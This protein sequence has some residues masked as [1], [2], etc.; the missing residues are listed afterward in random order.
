MQRGTMAHLT[1][2]D[3]W[4]SSAGCSIK[5]NN[6]QHF[7]FDLFGSAGLSRCFPSP[8]TSCTTILEQIRKFN[9]KREIERER[10]P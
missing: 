4:H 2:N 9:S 7:F 10:D 8:G 5:L 1:V 6:K 3:G